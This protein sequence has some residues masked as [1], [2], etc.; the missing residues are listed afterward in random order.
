MVYCYTAIKSWWRH[1]MEI[2]SVLLALCAGNSLV[3]DEFPSQW[4]VSWRSFDA[5]FDLRLNK[6]LS[7]QSKCWWFETPSCSLWRHY[8]GIACRYWY[9][10]NLPPL[11]C[12][13]W[14]K[15]AL[16]VSLW[17]VTRSGCW[18]PGVYPGAGTAWPCWLTSR[19]YCY[20]GKNVNT[21][22]MT[23]CAR[24]KTVVSPVHQ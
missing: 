19:D 18:P 16:D 1:Q 6:G 24:A 12:S 2:F 14:R 21:M 20:P 11:S 13:P 9:W 4:P 15:D 5:L 7:K 10:S 3:T 22:P 17:V 8:N 23:L